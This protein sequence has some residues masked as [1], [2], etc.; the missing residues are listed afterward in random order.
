MSAPRW[1]RCPRTLDHLYVY[2][3]KEA[4]TVGRVYKG[5]R[6]GKPVWFAQW[7]GNAPNLHR[8]LKDAKREIVEREAE[9]AANDPDFE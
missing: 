8:T 1:T 4:G 9:Y 5:L 6:F 2:G 7:A 3:D